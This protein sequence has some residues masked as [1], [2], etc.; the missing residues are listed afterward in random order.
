M[1]NR[2]SRVARVVRQERGIWTVEMNSS[3]WQVEHIR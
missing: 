1:N 2:E 3:T